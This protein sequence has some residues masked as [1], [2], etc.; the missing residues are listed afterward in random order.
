MKEEAKGCCRKEVSRIIF[1]HFY[2]D[3]DALN[4]RLQAGTSKCDGDKGMFDAFLEA[5]EIIVG[6]LWGKKLTL[7]K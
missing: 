6:L 7:Q 5:L 4:I 3:S 2:T 1:Y